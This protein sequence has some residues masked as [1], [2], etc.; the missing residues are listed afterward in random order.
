MILIA[1][2]FHHLVPRKCFL[3]I[4]RCNMF[5]SIIKDTGRPVVILD[6]QWNSQI[7]ALRNLADQNVLEGKTAV[8]GDEEQS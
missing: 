7:D 5:K 6:P 2:T 3:S 4:H 8:L 1:L